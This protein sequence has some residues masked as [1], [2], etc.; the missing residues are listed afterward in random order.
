MKTFWITLVCLWFSSLVFAQKKHTTTTP[1]DGE[2]T[3]AE[4]KKIAES[5]GYKG[6]NANNI[7]AIYWIYLMAKDPLKDN[8]RDLK[9]NLF[10]WI[11]DVEDVF[12]IY[13][14][15]QAKEIEI[16]SFPYKKDLLQQF[17]N[18]CCIF[19]LANPDKI[20]D[21][22]A[23]I[24]TGMKFACEAYEKIIKNTNTEPHYFFEAQCEK[25]LGHKTEKGIEMAKKDK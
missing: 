15:P 9:Q 14:S 6:T 21:N 8:N 20:K 5:Y 19:D 18:G 24:P 2:P 22:K 1:T 4:K 23:D 11:Q 12:V 10:A 13:D 25:Y 17:M 7:E 16:S 3:A